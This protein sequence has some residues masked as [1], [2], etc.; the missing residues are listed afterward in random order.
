MS[1]LT[2]VGVRVLSLLMSTMESKRA[3]FSGNLESGNLCQILSATNH[4]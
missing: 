2:H 4:V 3:A 1:E